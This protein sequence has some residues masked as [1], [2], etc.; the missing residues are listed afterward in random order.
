[1]VGKAWV[2]KK[3]LHISKYDDELRI[4]SGRVDTIHAHVHSGTS[5]ESPQT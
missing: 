1:M 3:I 2:S 4:L 5:R